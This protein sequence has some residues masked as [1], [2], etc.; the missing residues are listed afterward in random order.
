MKE[1]LYIV[2]V[3]FIYRAKQCM[4]DI[5]VIINPCK[6]LLISLLPVVKD[7]LVVRGV[8]PGILA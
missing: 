8:R 7:S 1:S 5:H 6:S 2:L 3:I 4:F